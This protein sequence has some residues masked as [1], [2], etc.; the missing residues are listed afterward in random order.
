MN[1]LIL[2][3]TALG[4]L[5][6]VTGDLRATVFIS[7]IVVLGVVFRF[8]QEI[9]TDRAAEKLKVMDSSAASVVREGK[10]T[11]GLLKLLVAGDIVHLAAGDMV[12]ADVRVLAAKDLFLDQ[13]ALI[14]EALPVEHKADAGSAGSENPI[15]RPNLCFLGSN[16]ESSSATAIVIHTGVKTYLGSLSAS[17]VGQR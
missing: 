4:R 13:S 14:G 8:V 3:L 9:G 6:Y 12:P 10:E 16:V 5:S 15:D 2:L 11:E 17:L 1:L 7:I